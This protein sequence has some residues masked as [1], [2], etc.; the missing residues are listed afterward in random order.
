M[1]TYRIYYAFS[2]TQKNPEILFPQEYQPSES[3]IAHCSDPILDTAA[4][5]SRLQEL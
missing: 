4:G 1:R 5:R 3:M 2:C